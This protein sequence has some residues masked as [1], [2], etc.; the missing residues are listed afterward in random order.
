MIFHILFNYNQYNEVMDEKIQKVL[1]EKISESTSRVN[2]I[3][4]LVNSLE[5]TKHLKKQPEKQAI[6]QNLEYILTSCFERTK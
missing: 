5:Q 1:E 6:F 3:T 2:E 4:S